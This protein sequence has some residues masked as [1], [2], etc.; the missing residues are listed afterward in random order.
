MKIVFFCSALSLWVIGCGD[1]SKPKTQTTNTSSGN[2]IT[3]PV[4]Y[5]GAVGEAKRKAEKTVD[6][7][8]LQQAITLFEE[9]ENR[10]PNNLDELKTKGFI[11]EIPK[12][13]YGSK[14]EYNSASGTVK[15]V[16]Q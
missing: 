12:A 9:Q 7:V 14:I 15:V 10:Y 1:S 11:R 16:K 6:V 5:L 13:P 8:T 3:A 2:P 4:D